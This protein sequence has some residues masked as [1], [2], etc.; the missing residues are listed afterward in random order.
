MLAFIADRH[1][2]ARPKSSNAALKATGGFLV[3]VGGD[4]GVAKGRQVVA[5]F[6]RLV[7]AI[8][9]GRRRRV[10]LKLFDAIVS[11]QQLEAR[12][13]QLAQRFAVSSTEF[14]LH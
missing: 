13:K 14:F 6:F 12:I 2:A 11:G 10:E 3:L 5:K 9:G 8:K 7:N 4:Y 1:N